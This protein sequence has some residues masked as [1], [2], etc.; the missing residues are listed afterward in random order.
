MIRFAKKSGLLLLKKKWRNWQSD[1]GDNA[2]DYVVAASREFESGGS[3]VNRYF[4]Y[5]KLELE[6]FAYIRT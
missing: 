4:S 6:Y 5:D 1:R 2:I 3:K